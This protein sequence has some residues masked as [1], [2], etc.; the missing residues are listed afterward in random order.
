MKK[1]FAIALLTIIPSLN[2]YAVQ[3]NFTVASIGSSNSTGTVFIETLETATSSM[4]SNKK[5]FRLSDTDKSAD[6][7]FALALAAQAQNKRIAI[8]Y[9]PTNCF[10]GGTI[11]SVFRLRK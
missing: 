4:C 10:E 11:I 7:L 6:R 3:Q 8:D 1:I 2:V 5:L 9:T